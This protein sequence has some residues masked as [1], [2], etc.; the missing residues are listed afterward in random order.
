MTEALTHRYI[1]NHPQEIV[2]GNTVTMKAPGEFVSLT[3]EDLKDVNN[4]DL[5]ESGK[6]LALNVAKGGDKAND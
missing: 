2:S 3:T 1:G 6:L 5:F 4:A